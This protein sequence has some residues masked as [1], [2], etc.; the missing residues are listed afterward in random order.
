MAMG[1]SSVFKKSDRG[2]AGPVAGLGISTGGPGGRDS[3]NN[4]LSRA[5]S[6][7][8][9]FSLLDAS[10]SSS[11]PST[12]SRSVSSRGPPR[13][14]SVDVVSAGGGSREA[15]LDTPMRKRLQLLP[16]TVSVGASGSG[17]KDGAEGDGDG[18]DARSDGSGGTEQ[19]AGTATVGSSMANINRVEMSDAQAKK[20]VAE[21]VKEIFAV[22]NVSEAEE[23]FVAL[24]DEHQ[25]KLV[26]AMINYALDK[27][28][29]DVRL[30]TD[31]FAKVS[32]TVAP[33]TFEAGF[34]STV[35]FLEDIAIDVPQ[36][37]PRIAKMLKGAG[38]P[39]DIVERLAGKIADESGGGTPPKEKLISAFDALASCEFAYSI[40]SFMHS[41][42]STAETYLLPL[43]F[44]RCMLCSSSHFVH[45]VYLLLFHHIP[46][47]LSCHIIYAVPC[48]FS[49]SVCVFTIYS[50]F[51]VS[52]SSFQPRPLFVLH[53][54]CLVSSYRRPYTGRF[55]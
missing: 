28:K 18:A 1:P 39:R 13:K 41:D 40:Y 43:W 16:R 44:G 25:S 31:V 3:S 32:G 8:N 24:P 30:T 23:C 29:D 27:K 10:D 45:P 22:R 19:D 14:P 48:T 46:V 21:D 53:A 26:H 36:V 4:S 34:E 47:S 49:P 37:Y 35:E 7:S 12:L 52:S 5:A 20:K 38:L 33:T 54:S 2:G 6:S 11:T 9:M 17:D 42:T 15:P 51:I 55:L 50:L